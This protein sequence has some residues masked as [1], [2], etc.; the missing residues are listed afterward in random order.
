L[1]RAQCSR[2]AGHHGWHMAENPRQAVEGK[3]PMC[4]DWRLLA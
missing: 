2:G 3:L 4:P 1:L